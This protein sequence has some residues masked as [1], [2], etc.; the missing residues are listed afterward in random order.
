MKLTMKRINI[1]KYDFTQEQINVTA[2]ADDSYIILYSDIAGS[3]EN[4]DS[5]ENIVQGAVDQIN[6]QGNFEN[7]ILER[8]SKTNE[9]NEYLIPVD[10]T[11]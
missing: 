6:V 10:S 2:F 1:T 4:T 9:I 5:S 3:Y 8:I 7:P 11:T